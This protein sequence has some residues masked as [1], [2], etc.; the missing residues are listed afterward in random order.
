MQALIDKALSRGQPRYDKTL[1][2]A[3]RVTTWR[4]KSP[5]NSDDAKLHRRLVRAA[6][7]ADLEQL[8]G[9]YCVWIEKA[10][11]EHPQDAQAA[12]VGWVDA[13]SQRRRTAPG[14]Y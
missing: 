13:T 1:P 8:K 11:K 7:G 5:E 10:K 4:H 6:K 14:H 2:M 9:Q 3:D 12:F